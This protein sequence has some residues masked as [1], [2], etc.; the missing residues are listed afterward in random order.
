MAGPRSSE[1]RPDTC[2]PGSSPDAKIVL[3]A[4]VPEPAAAMAKG[5]PVAARDP[6]PISGDTVIAPRRA[7]DTGVLPARIADCAITL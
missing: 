5:P 7:I 2:I 3:S 6:P 1:C 4:D